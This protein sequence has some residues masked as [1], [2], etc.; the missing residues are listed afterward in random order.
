[1]TFCHV[2]RNYHKWRPGLHHSYGTEYP[3]ANLKSGRGGV[4]VITADIHV[5]HGVEHPANGLPTD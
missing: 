2:I 3:Q 5:P 4:T 1:M